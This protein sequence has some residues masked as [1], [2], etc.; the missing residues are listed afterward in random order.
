M[1]LAYEDDVRGYLG[2][3]LRL[4]CVLLS[5]GE[6]G[7]I[8]SLFPG[9]AATQE[10]TRLVVVV[11]DSPKTPPRR[12]TMTRPLINRAETVHLMVVGA[13]KASALRA[14]LEH[15][16]Y[17]DRCPARASS[18][19]DPVL[20]CGWTGPPR[21]RFPPREGKVDADCRSV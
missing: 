13:S 2:P 3:R 4:D 10:A 1:A 7:H 11:I 15:S 20:R 21:R 6:D 19:S 9:H 16:G 14:T 12:V 8:A 17:V 18:G 5:L